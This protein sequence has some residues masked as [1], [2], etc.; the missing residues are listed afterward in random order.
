MR[1]T[2]RYC[3]IPIAL[4]FAHLIAS[5]AAPVRSQPT[6][7]LAVRVAGGGS[8]TPQQTA[9]ITSALENHLSRSGLRFAERLSDADFVVIIDFIPDTI[10]QNRGR[11][12]IIGVETSSRLRRAN[13]DE[14]SVEAKEWAQKLRSYEQWIERQAKEST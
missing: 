10:D 7:L 14:M 5:C 2:L 1:T 13:Q 11:V 3:F 6:A 8:P 4:L 12:K 9:N